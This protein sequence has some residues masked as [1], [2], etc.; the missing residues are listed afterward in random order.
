MKHPSVLVCICSTCT[1]NV[2]RQ[3]DTTTRNRSRRKRTRD[4]RFQKVYTYS[5]PP[6]YETSDQDSN[7][8][9]SVRAWVDIRVVIILR[10]LVIILRAPYRTFPSRSLFECSKRHL[11][12]WTSKVS[13]Y[14]C[15]EKDP[16]QH[17]YFNK[18]KNLKKKTYFDNS[19]SYLSFSLFSLF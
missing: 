4:K 16:H 5:L 13:W 1:G 8:C 10:V 2:Y 17:L 9:V 6:D 14:L 12:P 7:L 18:K 3:E 15:L 11:P 19:S